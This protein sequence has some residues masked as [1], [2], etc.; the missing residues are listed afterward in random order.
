MPPSRGSPAAADVAVHALLAVGW[1]LVFRSGSP[2]V[3]FAFFLASRVAYVAFAGL[4]LRAQ[5]ATGWWTRRW[6]PEEGFHRFRRAVTVLMNNDGAAIAILCWNDRGSLRSDLPP[7]AL[8][9][10]GAALV[11][12]GIGTKSWAAATL[13]RGSYHWQSFFIPPEATRFVATGP[14][15]WFANP[16]YTVGYAHAYG[17]ALAMGS[18][19]GLLAAFL[20]QCGILV[21]NFWAERPHTERMRVRTAGRDSDG[22]TAPG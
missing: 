15:R 2:T 14:Y 9:A 20:A 16:M 5:D 10:T 4:S 17:I 21:L 11:A 19:R 13:G 12:L 1:Y 8:V 18:L 22:P 6:G 3:A 7:W